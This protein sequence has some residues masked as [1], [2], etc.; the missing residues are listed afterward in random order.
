MKNRIRLFFSV[1]TP[2]STF[3]PIPDCSG[4][5]RGDPR[6]RH[7]AAHGGVRPAPHACHRARADTSAVVRSRCPAGCRAR[8]PHPTPYT[9]HP[10]PYTPH[11]TPYILNP[12]LYTLHPTPHTPHPTPYTLNP[13]P[14]T[15]H[16]EPYTP[17][18]TPHTLHPHLTPYTPHSTP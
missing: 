2:N 5:A 11:P 9:L 18:P 3:Y 16:P 6:G 15:P 13:T 14:Y 12:T 8:R 4:R 17:H 10:T 1:R 7:D